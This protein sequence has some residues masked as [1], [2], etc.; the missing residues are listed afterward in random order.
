[1]VIWFIGKSGS[2][3]SEIGKRLYNKLKMEIPNIVYLD[4]D[5]LRDAISWDLG[6]SLKDR[7][8]SEKRRSQLCKLLSDQNIS[9]IC[10]ALSNSP[11][12][13]EWNNQ[14]INNYYEIYIKVNQSVLYKRDSKGLYQKY[15]NKKINN[16]V[17]EDIPFHKPKNPWIK[18]NNNGKKTPDE[19][20]D[21]IMMA[22][23]KDKILD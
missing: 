14:N 3:K 19:I 6:H 10:A 16:V 2:G 17:G 7:H 5:E 4:G 23:K 11:D 9:V 22:I 13:R 8:I 1:M 12:L 15:N 18:I 20:V 21:K